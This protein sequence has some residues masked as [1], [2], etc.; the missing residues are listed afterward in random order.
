MEA[1]SPSSP[2]GDANV[3]SPQLPESLRSRIGRRL[4]Q[5]TEAVYSRKRFLLYGK[6]LVASDKPGCLATEPIVFR[7]NDAGA[8]AILRSE[9]AAYETGKK[10]AAALDRQVREGEICVSG[11]IGQELVYYGWIQFR[12]RQLARRTSIPI[13]PGTG[14]IYRCFTRP[15]HRGKHIYP[16]ALDF[17]CRWLAAEGYQRALIDHQAQNRASQTGILRAGMQPLAEYVVVKILWLRW[18]VPDETFRRLASH[19]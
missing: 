12:E 16:A 7:I 1:S 10:A 13:P 11:W 3:T 5:L 4:R 2:G 8:F 18:A 17:M 19:A 9:D 14:F 6:E 15:D